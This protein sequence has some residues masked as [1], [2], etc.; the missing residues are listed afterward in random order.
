MPAFV[1]QLGCALSLIP[2]QGVRRTLTPRRLFEQIVEVEKDRRLV[3]RG[4]SRDIITS[5]KT[6]T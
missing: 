5:V 4:F 6:R 2:H 1:A 3:G